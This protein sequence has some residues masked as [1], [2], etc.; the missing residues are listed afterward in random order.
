MKRTLWFGAALLLTPAIAAWAYA[1]SGRVPLSVAPIAAFGVVPWRDGI[2]ATAE[3][4][5]TTLQPSDLWALHL[6][7]RAYGDTAIAYGLDIPALRIELQ[8]RLRAPAS[9]MVLHT[10]PAPEARLPSAPLE[11]DTA[12]HDAAGYLARAQRGDGSF[13]Y[14]VL[15]S[16]NEELPG[17]N[18]AR[19]TGAMFF[20][21]QTLGHGTEQS[22]L[23]AA[24]R[25]M[26]STLKSCASHICV[27]L[28]G[29]RYASLGAAAIGVISLA[30]WVAHDPNNLSAKHDL[31]RLTAFVSSAQ[32][33]SGDFWHIYD[34]GLP[35]PEGNGLGAWAQVSMPYYSGEATLALARAAEVLKQPALRDQARRGLAFLS[36]H[37][38][39]FFGSKY[40]A[41]EEHWTCQA[42][43]ALWDAPEAADALA[44]C[45]DW[46]RAQRA[47]Q[48]GSGET[49]YDSAGAYG[50]GPWLVPRTTPAA[51]RSE[52]AG[53][54]LMAWRK[55]VRASLSKPDAAEERRLR[56]QLEL[57]VSYL[58]R[59]QLPGRYALLMRD[60]E[61]MR[62]AWAGSESDD[63]VQIDFVQHAGSALLRWQETLADERAARANLK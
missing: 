51:S 17:Y 4:R 8:T 9:E 38:W 57:A 29:E 25:Y 6:Y 23:A 46:N 58:L 59:M 63:R 1:R 37:G 31:E 44:F 56:A 54:T 5:S 12:I 14:L 39:R 43:D 47:T 27:V 20:L 22:T 2:E 49:P 19:H 50:F 53:A 41:G 55:R 10:F 52:A 16:S 42:L 26:Q 30:E 3:G 35:N 40:W 24:H 13:R 36:H 34:H 45:I 33:P 61:A 62:G 11:L 28:P 15:A 7:D 32:K 48:Y 18:M 60:P 21:A